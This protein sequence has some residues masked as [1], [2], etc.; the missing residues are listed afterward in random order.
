MF[1]SNVNS[2]PKTTSV[3]NIQTQGA[4]IIIVQLQQSQLKEAVIDYSTSQSKTLQSTILI[5]DIIFVCLG[6]HI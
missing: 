3:Q 5:M 1:A 4:F 6:R 2:S